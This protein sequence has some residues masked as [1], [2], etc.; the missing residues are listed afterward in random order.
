MGGFRREGDGGEGEKRR[1]KGRA[2]SAQ[3]MCVCVFYLL[4]GLLNIN[5]CSRTHMMGLTSQ[6]FLLS[7]SECWRAYHSF[8][9]ASESWK[10]GWK[11]G[12]P[13][14]GSLP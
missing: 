1:K 7:G 8:P 10:L 12:G 4:C 11:A 3:N 14:L 6:R 2:K 13:A 9:H 5:D